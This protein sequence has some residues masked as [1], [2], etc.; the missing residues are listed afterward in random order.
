[1]KLMLMRH[2]QAASSDID[3]AQGLTDAGRQAID[4]LA[5]RLHLRGVTFGCAYHSD[6]TRARQTAEIMCA[7]LAP[8]ATRLEIEGLRP[9]DDPAMLLPQIRSWNEDV[10]IVGHL[11][12]LPALLGKLVFNAGYT[13]FLPGTVVCLLRVESVN[14]QISWIERPA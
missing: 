4:N 13:E 14:W 2:G 12:F 11:P 1:M 10:L 9:N 7:R 8:D 6:K 5:E 3:P